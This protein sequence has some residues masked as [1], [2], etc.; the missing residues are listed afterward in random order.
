MRRLTAL[1]GL[2]A[3]V[4]LLFSVGAEGVSP[5]PI[6]IE[7]VGASYSLSLELDNATSC[8]WSFGDGVGARG[9]RAYHTY[10]ESG[11]FTITAEITY[12]DGNETAAE[13]N[14]TVKLDGIAGEGG[15][16]TIT[17]LGF[18][19]TAMTLLISGVGSIAM[20]IIYPHPILWRRWTPEVRAAIGMFTIMIAWLMAAGLI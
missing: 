10:N 17:I 6:H 8:V 7:R 5:S 2:G 14:V 20:A 1:V 15:E 16:R 18:S 11:N 3:L 4:A 19:F 12:A 9:P 13:Q